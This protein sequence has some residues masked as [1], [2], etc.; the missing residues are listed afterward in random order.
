MS[1]VRR[2][3]LVSF[4]VEHLLHRHQTLFE[5]RRVRVVVRDLGRFER[6]HAEY[7]RIALG[8]VGNAVSVGHNWSVAH[9]TVRRG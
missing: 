8:V 6:R 4:H 5:G 1:V 7:Q 3:L 2:R 9:K